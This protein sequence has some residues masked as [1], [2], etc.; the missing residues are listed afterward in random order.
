M[1]AK[2]ASLAVV[3]SFAFFVALGQ[4]EASRITPVGAQ[5]GQAVLGGQTLCGSS[6]T[7]GI[8]ACG[9]QPCPGSTM[10]APCN[11]LPVWSPT[12]PGMY[13]GGNPPVTSCY[14]CGTVWCGQNGPTNVVSCTTP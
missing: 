13:K 14:V 4:T 10:A 5:E 12:G 8:G 1:M 7:Q 6:Y 9:V 2:L 3:L 11:A